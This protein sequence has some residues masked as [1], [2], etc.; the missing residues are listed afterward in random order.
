M[1][2]VAVHPGD[3]TVIL[4]G[5]G[6][7]E[8]GHLFSGLWKS[9]DS[10][11]SW[12]LVTR[13]I[14]F[15]GHGPTALFADVLAFSVLQPNL[16]A[17]A[18]ETRGLFLSRDAGDSWEH[19]G[20]RG[21]RIACLGFVPNAR[22]QETL[23][24]G[25][26]ADSEFTILGLGHPFSELTA[27][28]RI[29][30]VRFKDGKPRPELCCGLPDFGAVN[31]GFGAHENFVTFATTR[32]IYYTW[33][34]GNVFSQRRHD[35]PA[36]RLFVALGYRAYK[37]ETRPGEWRSQSTSY[38][39]PFEGKGPASVYT[40]PERTTGIW[41]ALQDEVRIEGSETGLELNSGVSCILPDRDD[42]DTLYLCNRD[43]ILKT[44]DAGKTYRR[45]WP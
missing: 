5:G 45:V 1:R 34:H 42:A 31:I 25:T 13:E 44:T 15:D 40:V 38:A 32:G 12:Q 28:G 21:E 17:A 20:M 43:G 23:V 26:F 19:I 8:D 2:S 3:N 30:W 18:G 35:I 24:V 33:Q 29:Y 9:R 16:V 39:I 11:A 41:Y 22:D 36:D 10:A 4:R 7:I 37:R 6:R 27:P 14:D